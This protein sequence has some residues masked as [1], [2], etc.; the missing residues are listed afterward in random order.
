MIS[1]LWRWIK[2]GLRLRRSRLRERESEL[3]RALSAKNATAY[4]ASEPEEPSAS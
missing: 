2:R 1:T 4:C 3:A